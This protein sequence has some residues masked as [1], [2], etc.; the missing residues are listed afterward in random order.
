M[1][2]MRIHERLNEAFRPKTVKIGD[3]V[4]M[5]ENLNIDDGSGD[6]YTD[7]NGTTYYSQDAAIRIAKGVPGWHLPTAAE[8]KEA[9]KSSANLQ[10]DLGVELNGYHVIGDLGE[11]TYNRY[12]KGFFWTPEKTT[13]DGSFGKYAYF[14]NGPKHDLY[15]LTDRGDSTRFMA[16]VRLVKD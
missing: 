3:Q 15:F 4:W 10:K 14:T 7:D 12:V 13:D 1:L 6:V 2:T 5:A 8:W 9:G 11:D 16:N